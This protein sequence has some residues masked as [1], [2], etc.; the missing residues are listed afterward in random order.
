MSREKEE[1]SARIE[2]LRQQL[3]QYVDKATR[4]PVRCSTSYHLSAE[5][6]TLINQY[7]ISCLEQQHK[8]ANSALR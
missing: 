3:N 4:T 5:L 2:E 1:L 7:T 6:D 8:K